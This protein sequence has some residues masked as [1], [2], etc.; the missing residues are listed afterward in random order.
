M[1]TKYWN[2][3]LQSF[4]QAY[5]NED[6]DSSLLLMQYYGFIEADNEKFIKTVYAVKKN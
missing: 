1:Q 5:E 6:F 3:Q 2:E 4:T